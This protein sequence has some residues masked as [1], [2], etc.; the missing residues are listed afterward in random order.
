[1]R[2]RYNSMSGAR[3]ETHQ[4]VT[5]RPMMMRL[6][7]V[8]LLALPGSIGGSAWD[9]VPAKWNLAD[10][11]RILQDSP[12]SPAGVKL[13]REFTSR[14]TDPE[15]GR[16]TD[17]P[18][19]ANTANPVPG[20]QISRSKPLPKVPVIWWSSKTIRL[21]KQRLRQLSNP[22]LAGEPLRAD[23]L[24]DYVLV[25]EGSEPLRILQDTKEDL[26]D[27][28][29]LELTN[30]TTLDLEGVRL[31][32]G[33]KLEEPRVEFH[34]PREVDGRATLNPES[35]RIVFHCKASAKIPRPGHDNSLT[36]RAEFR[37]RAMRVHGVPD[38]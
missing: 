30:G 25:I 17:A 8:A 26:H 29:F 6:I 3:I 4:V 22:A 31:F 16:V 15:T 18:V 12:W 10:V 32:E 24:P 21:A 5:R 11:S 9:K 27:T 36:L 37:P 2:V 1:M 34:F 14:H 23:E 35:E 33:T 20:I 28:V 13:E 38:L 7:L 19:N